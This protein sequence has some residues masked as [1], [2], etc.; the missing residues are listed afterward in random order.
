MS[1]EEARRRATEGIRRR[2]L[3]KGMRSQALPG[4][5]HVAAVASLAA[6]CFT[7]LLCAGGGA[8]TKMRY[9]THRADIVEVFGG[10]GEIS[11]QAHR[12]GLFALQPYDS[13]YGCD[14]RD[15]QQVESLEQDM[16]RW[17]PRLIVIEFPCRVWSPLQ[18]LAAGNS[19]EKRRELRRRQLE[20]KPFLQLTE[21]LFE[22]Q[23]AKDDEALAENPWT[24]MARKE[25]EIQRLENDPRCYVALSHQCRFNKRH[26]FSGMLVKSR[27]SGS[28]QARR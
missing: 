14:L 9:G 24:S 25:P 4:A 12:Q 5:V 18:R 22:M 20:D 7:A 21:R 10:F 26:L 3:K 13:T 28:A 15:P 27:P 1:A 6:C 19:L 23:L 17:N 11:M 8:W 2:S 16:V